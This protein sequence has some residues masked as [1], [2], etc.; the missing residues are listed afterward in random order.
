MTTYGTAC[1]DKISGTTG[2]DII[3]GLG[4]D[5]EIMSAE[6][7]GHRVRRRRST[8]RS[9]PAPAPTLSMGGTGD[10]FIMGGPENDIINGE[11]GDDTMRGEEGNDI[12]I[13]YAGANVHDGDDELLGG[14]RN[15]FLAGYEGHDY[16]HGGYG[17]DTL[18][19]HEIVPVRDNFV[20]GQ[21]KDTFKVK[22]TIEHNFVNRDDV[23]NDNFDYPVTNK[24]ANDWIHSIQLDTSPAAHRRGVRPVVS[25]RL[26]RRARSTT[27]P[28]IGGL[29]S[30]GSFVVHQPPR[31][32]VTMDLRGD[33]PCFG[34]TWCAQWTPTTWSSEPGPPAWRSPTR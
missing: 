5:D 31:L 20:G 22:D 32:R 16:H 28:A 2:K 13:S 1:D 9:T 18:E 19:S 3:Y 8:T 24:N 26:P 21:D 29:V 11:A 27:R 34:E 25:I 6:R 30:R 33:T 17:D 23:Q 10:D 12:L 14:D 15:D 7:R 4:G